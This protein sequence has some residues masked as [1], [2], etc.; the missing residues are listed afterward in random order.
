MS[1]PSDHATDSN[2]QRS[3]PR[4]NRLSEG[5]ADDIQDL[6]DIA[7]GVA[8]LGRVPDTALDVVFE[9]EESDGVYRSPQS[10]R[11]LEDVDAVFSALNHALDPTDLARDA[12]QSP[13]EDGLIS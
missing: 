13:N 5:P 12:A 1:A 8:L 4:S 6:L 10:R 7:I 9:D 11:L 3:R 2:A